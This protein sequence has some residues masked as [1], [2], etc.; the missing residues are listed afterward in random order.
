M[1]NRKSG[2][3]SVKCRGYSAGA[4][5]R[6]VGGYTKAIFKPSSVQDEQDDVN[7]YFDLHGYRGTS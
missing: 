5:I 2:T 1:L 3:Q 7:G 4:S 6:Y